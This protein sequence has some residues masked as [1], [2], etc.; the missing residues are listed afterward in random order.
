MLLE[1]NRLSTIITA[2]HENKQVVYHKKT[3]ENNVEYKIF[4][5]KIYLGPRYLKATQLDI[6][7]TAMWIVD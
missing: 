6:E 5:S 2:A 1:I 3:T 4:F 7:I